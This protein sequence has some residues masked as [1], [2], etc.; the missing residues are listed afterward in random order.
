M[1][2]CF[3]CGQEFPS[4]RSL[5][6]HIKV[7][8]IC[9]GDYYVKHLNKRDLYTDEPIPFKNY[10][11]YL[12]QDFLSYKNYQLWLD[13]R[14][15]EEARQYIL[16]Q[17]YEKIAEKDIK[18]SPPN[19]YWQLGQM[20]DTT[21]IKKH[22]GSYLNFCKMIELKCNFKNLPKCFWESC[23]DLPILIDTREQQPLEF[24]NS[25][26]QKLDFGDYTTNG[27]YYSKTFIDRKSESDFLGT[28][29]SGIDRFKHEMDRC[30]SFNSYM[31]VLVESNITK[32]KENPRNR[33]IHL[34]YVWHN[35]KELILQYPKNLQII[36]GQSRSGVQKLVP[37]ILFFGKE[38]WGVDLQYFIEERIKEKNVVK[39]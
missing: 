22:F 12:E 1:N 39:R 19:L 9:L 23:P 18:E 11:Q 28:F 14:T 33:K 17:A 26:K 2:K 10:T 24:K 7:H 34:E 6:A 35:C 13:S 16:A 38:L 31:F 5:H 32:I 3:D 29:G 15:H 21:E 36:F 8:D 27:Q 25:I 30:V 37:K 4:L 20:A